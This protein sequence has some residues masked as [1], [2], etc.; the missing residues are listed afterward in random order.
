MT[1]WMNLRLIQASVNPNHK[2]CWHLYSRDFYVLLRMLPIGLSKALLNGT[3]TGGFTTQTYSNSPNLF[4][5]LAP[6]LPQAPKCPWLYFPFPQWVELE[7]LGYSAILHKRDTTNTAKQYVF[8]SEKGN[9]TY[10]ALMVVQAH[11]QAFGH[12]VEMMIKWTYN[13][14]STN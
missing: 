12:L 6:N 13:S 2:A 7:N 5:Q 11:W 9:I 8:L 10:I 1:K 3:R 4:Y 14:S